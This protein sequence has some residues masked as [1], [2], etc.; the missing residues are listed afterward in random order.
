MPEQMTDASPSRRSL[1]LACVLVGSF[2]TAIETTIV[3]TAVPQIVGDVGGFALYSWVF[4]V[5]LM[6]NA[7]TSVIYGKLADLYGRRPVLIAGIVIFIVGSFLCGFAWSMPSLIGFRALQGIGAGA[8][9]PLGNTII[10]DYYPARERAK[11]QGYIGAVW[12]SSAIV[13][14]LIG[15]VIVEHISWAWIFWLNIPIGVLTIVGLQLFLHENV[16]HRRHDIDYPGALL[17]SIAVI[18]FLL[19]LTARDGALAGPGPN[20]ILGAVFVAGALLFWVRERRAAEPMVSFALWSDPLIATANC[21]SL[22]LGALVIGMTSLVPIY[23]QAVLAHSAMVAGMALTTVAIGWPLASLL[24]PQFFRRIGSRATLRTGGVITALGGAMFLLL[25]PASSIILVGAAG[26]V[27][28]FGIGLVFI[29]SLI[30]VQSKV[31]W[32]RRGSATASLVLTRNLGST[33]GVALLGAILNF[34]L[35]HSPGG[36][37]IDTIRQLIDRSGAGSGAPPASAA[38]LQGLFGGLSLTFWALA[39]I[40]LATLVAVLFVPAEEFG[41]SEKPGA[42]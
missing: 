21:V 15:G 28:G 22:L 12:G 2:M 5:F 37:S 23:V 6:A 17:F 8:I 9:Q 41:E 3:A 35:A 1:V 27:T 42:G 13:G 38:L 34:G 31:D 30:L 10:G 26:F 25:G 39:A 33:M 36:A 16:A 19:L 14:P 18:A 4:S 40:A 11:V 20:V 7:V 32:S 29:T 24:S